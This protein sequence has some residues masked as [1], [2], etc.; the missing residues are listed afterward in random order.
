MT[1]SADTGRK[2]F[3]IAAATLLWALAFWFGLLA[4]STDRTVAFAIIGVGLVFAMY[5][6]AFVGR[7]DRAADRAFRSALVAI[8]VGIVLVAA[9]L[10][11]GSERFAVAA[12]VAAPGV[13][14]A[15]VIPPSGDRARIVARLVIVVLMTFVGLALYGTERTVFGLVAPLYVLPLIGVADIYFDR[16][17]AGAASSDG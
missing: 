16:V 11:F 10:A 8:A 14:G 9:A 5:V 17:R 13:G 2:W 12:A 4:E 3:A 1:D 6:V 7:V 15:L